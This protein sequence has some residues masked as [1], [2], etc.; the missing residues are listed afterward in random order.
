MG[1]MVAGDLDGLHTLVMIVNIFVEVFGKV[2]KNNG[3][4]T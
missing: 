1:G 4:H 3:Y 2:S